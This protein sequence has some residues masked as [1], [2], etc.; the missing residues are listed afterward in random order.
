MRR[1]GSDNM[2]ADDGSKLGMDENQPIES[3][4]VITSG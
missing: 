4:M 3:K 1:F 2:K